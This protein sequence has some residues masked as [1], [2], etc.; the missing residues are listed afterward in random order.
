M[1]LPDHIREHVSRNDLKVIDITRKPGRNKNW[2]LK[3]S[4]GSSIFAKQFAGEAASAR[5]SAS[6]RAAEIPTLSTPRIIHCD[7]HQLTLY[8]EPVSDAS[9][10]GL[11]LIAPTSADSDS[12]MRA[13]GEAVAKIHALTDFE[14]PPDSR[15]VDLSTLFSAIPADLFSRL[16]G[17]QLDAI[18]I[19]HSD[20]IVRT[21]LL[22][23]SDYAASGGSSIIH[24][25][26]RLD[27]FAFA[28]KQVTVTDLETMRIGRREMD[29]A[30][31]LGSLLHEAV[32]GTPM[33]PRLEVFG[34]TD[35]THDEVLKVGDQRI[36]DSAAAFRIFLASYFDSRHNAS[37]HSQID[38][39]WTVRLAGAFMFDRLLASA[40]GSAVLSAAFLGS[41]G[42]GRSLILEPESAL[43]QL[44]EMEA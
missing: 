31:I 43:S 9:V 6:L 17:A 40:E 30:G 14:S 8:F 33:D 1:D 24:G 29:L 34:K 25:D 5:Y 22:E 41:A 38:M 37:R 16:T 12:H 19:I 42:V 7:E 28:G 11:D 39:V 35:L 2:L 15:V 3:L 27:Q 23:V 4:D 10:Y 36:Q 18:R 13:V 32:S 20:P 26:C 44:L 21:S